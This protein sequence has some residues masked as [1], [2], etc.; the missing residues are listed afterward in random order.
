MDLSHTCCIIQYNV[1]ERT[2]FYPVPFY[3]IYTKAD[4]NKIIFPWN[5]DYNV[6]KT[7]GIIPFSIRFFKIGDRLTEKNDAELILT[8]NLSTVPSQIVIKKALNEM[9]IDKDDESY[10]QP[11]DKE[12]LMS[13]VDRRMESLSRKI[14]WTILDNVPEE[15]EEETEE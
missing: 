15:M 2:K 12:I 7:P 4:E 8:Y 13:Y 10:L 9:Q 1:N 5:L 14:Y 6:T 11:T 3:D